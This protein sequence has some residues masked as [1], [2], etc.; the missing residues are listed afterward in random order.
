MFLT[1]AD[2]NGIL[3]DKGLGGAASQGVAIDDLSRDRRADGRI[4]VISI[5]ISKGSW[6]ARLLSSDL[7]PVSGDV[8]TALGRQGDQTPRVQRLHD[9]LDLLETE[10][11]GSPNA[12]SRRTTRRCAAE[13]RFPAAPSARA[14]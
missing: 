5:S 4:T 14:L 7:E 13:G 12:L 3:I 6:L 9:P 10:V 2:H 11:V 8:A 1:R